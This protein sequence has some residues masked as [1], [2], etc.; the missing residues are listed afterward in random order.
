LTRRGAPAG[1]AA[2]HAGARTS[3][4][5]RFLVAS[6][7]GGERLDVYL[8]RKL[9]VSR[10]R[11][12]RW[13]RDGCVSVDGAAE[14][15]PARAVAD[16][17]TIECLPID[18]PAESALEAQPGALRV[19]WEDEHLIVLDKTPDVAV[20]PGAG[21]ADRTL[22][23]FLLDRFPEIA[24]VGHPRRPGVVH[25]LDLGTSGVLAVARTETA[26]QRLT[27]AF[28]ER[29][30]RKLYLAVVYGRPD[31]LRGEIDAAI[32][33]DPKDRKRM[34]VRASRGRAALTRYRTIAAD[35]GL[36]LLELD[37]RT[38]R[39]HQI[40]VHLK[41]RGL[42]IVGDPVYGEARWR[43]AA[44]ERRTALRSFPR[45]ALH[46]W[47]LTLPHPATGDRL[48]FEAPLPDDLRRLWR[49]A[50]GRELALTALDET[51]RSP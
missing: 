50:T 43:S 29:E 48:S 11:V 25:R 22:V 44:P 19:I 38:G 17:D 32:G 45:P 2:S 6:E 9:D 46:A 51:L 21:R 4:P 24:A 35:A 8:A 28:A 33:R 15:R 1:T 12:Q 7:D 30:V 18:A 40:R 36:A 39:T 14:P 31:P 3:E 37:L 23:N 26:Y 42:P 20:H 41:S 34:T 49:D 27:R 5:R 13:I 10:S 16:G 47:R